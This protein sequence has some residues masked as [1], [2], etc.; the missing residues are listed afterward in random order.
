MDRQQAIQEIRSRI[1]CSDYLTKSKD[2]L[3][4]C[5]FCGSGTGPHGTGAVKYY[6]DTNTWTCFACKKS[7]DVIDLYRQ[8]TGAEFPKAVDEL[9]QAAGVDIDRKFNRTEAPRTSFNGSR[10]ISA[11]PEPKAPEKGLK[12]PQDESPDYTAYYEA[13][14]KMLDSPEGAAGIA[15]LEQRQVRAAALQC[16]VGFDPQA[17]PA[18]A[19]GAIGEAKRLFPCPRIIIPCSKGH[20]VARRT[21]GGTDRKKLNPKGSTPAIFNEK[22]LFAPEVQ[23]VFITEGAFDALSV[24]EAGGDAIALNSTNNA[25]KLID[26]LA[27]TATAA[28]LILCL[29][30]DGAGSKA[31]QELREGLQGLKIPFITADICNGLKDPNEAMT[32]DYPTFEAAVWGAIEDAKATREKLRQEAQQEERERMERTGAG[33]IDA[34]LETV[35][36]RKYEPIPTG[37][38]DIDAALTGGF[39]RQTLILLGAAPGAGKTALA[40]W[41]F[42]GM[43]QRGTSCLFLNLEMSREQILARSIARIAARRGEHITPA[44]VKQGYKWDVAQEAIVMAA[45]Q[46]YKETIAPRMIYNPLDTTTDL[47]AILQYMEEEAQR[48]EAA[49]LP[50][51]LVVIDY[52]QIITGNAREDE[53]SL[54]KRAVSS[55]KHFAMKHNTVVFCIMAHNRAANQSGNVSMA[56]GRDTSALEYSADLQLGLAFTECLDRDGSKGKDFDELTPEERQRV[57]LKITKGRDAKIGAEVDLIFNG[58]TMTYTPVDKRREDPRQAWAEAPTMTM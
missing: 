44:E 32:A 48:A 57:T 4:C 25:R 27:Q 26:K 41:V 58:E 33:M 46:E 28:T 43:A 1:R 55:L 39:T 38:A 2:G 12:T 47:D 14:K 34:F 10:G 30:N 17:D 19:P 37:I 5:P 40:Q 35:R 21:D 3:Y 11:P 7:G 15:Y 51:P 31:A 52:L 42:E 56:S 49:G 53:V 50:A 13:C 9:A 23:E 8:A 18:N 20:Y 54:I 6:P 16:G 24:M 36:T 22:V 29:D 45:A